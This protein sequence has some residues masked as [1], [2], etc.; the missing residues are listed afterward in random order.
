MNA[1][2]DQLKQDIGESKFK[3]GDRVASPSIGKACA[4]VGTIELA[5]GYVG[6]SCSGWSYNVVDEHGAVWCRSDADLTLVYSSADV[7]A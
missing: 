1:I 4:F 3:V 2:I 7:A 6:Q 5:H